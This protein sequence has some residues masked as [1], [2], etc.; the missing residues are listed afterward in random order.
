MLRLCSHGQSYRVIAEVYRNYETIQFA[1]QIAP[2]KSSNAGNEYGNDE[3]VH[4]F[5]STPLTI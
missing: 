1:C 3:G 2:D 5:H 4:V